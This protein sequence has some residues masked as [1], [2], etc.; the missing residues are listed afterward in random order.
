MEIVYL[1]LVEDGSVLAHVKGNSILTVRFKQDKWEISP[2]SAW[3]LEREKGACEISE[4]EALAL[5]N[6][7]SPRKT[8]EKIFEILE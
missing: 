3:I 4:A 6:N 2:S 1:K 8:L 5:C 7:I